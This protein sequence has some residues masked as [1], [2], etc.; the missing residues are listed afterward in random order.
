[1]RVLLD[2]QIFVILTQ[3]GIEDVSSRV[4]KVV[5]DEDS[6]LLLS[7]VSITEMAV[8]ASISKLAITAPDVSKAAEDLRLTLIPFEARHAIRMFGL[9]L[10]HRDRFDRMLVATALSEGVPMI[11]S[12]DQLKRY[13]GL[14]VIL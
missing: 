1:V 2:T 4:R 3:Q 13:R 7:A 6:E 9:P 14:K 12:N 11:T 5:Q 10:H 8:K